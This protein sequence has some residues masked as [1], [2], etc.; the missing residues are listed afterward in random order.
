MASGK[1]GVSRP[2]F[3]IAF[4]SVVVSTAETGSRVVKWYRWVA[5]GDVRGLRILV[6]R[7]YF[8]TL[9]LSGLA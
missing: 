5:V 7:T 8:S 1:L 4:F 2:D 3:W 9:N 6:C